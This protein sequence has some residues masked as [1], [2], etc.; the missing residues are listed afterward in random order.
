MVADAVHSSYLRAANHLSRDSLVALLY[1]RDAID[2]DGVQ[3]ISAKEL[4]KAI[5]DWAAEDLPVE[6]CRMQ[7]E[8]TVVFE[9]MAEEYPVVEAGA[10]S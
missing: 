3:D 6:L 1:S 10:V 4:Q 9:K 5:R 8:M 2:C 7:T